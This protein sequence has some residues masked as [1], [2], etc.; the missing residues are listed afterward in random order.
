M[1]KLFITTVA[2]VS[3]VS[4]ASAQ[5]A[6]VTTDASATIN[7]SV[8]TVTTSAPPEG[9]L[10]PEF[11]TGDSK[12]DRQ[13]AALRKEMVTKIKAIQDEYHKKVKALVGERKVMIKEKRADIKAQVKEVKEVK[14]E[15]RQEIKTIR[16]ETR[17]EVRGTSTDTIPQGSA[18]G[19][20]RRFFGQPKENPAAE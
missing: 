17:E 2:L 1:N 18:W 19:F 6:T 15:A 14:K 10:P 7:A 3:L 20:F 8:Q 11:T 5:E 9:A 4:F 16:K 13:V 12:V